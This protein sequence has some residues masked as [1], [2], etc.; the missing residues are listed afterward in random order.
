MYGNFVGTDVTGTSELGNHVGILVSSNLDANIGGASPGQGNLISGNR[1][2]GV[3]VSRF[4]FG[5]EVYGNRIGTD[6]TGTLPLGN[7]SD[8]VLIGGANNF[9]GGT[10]S[11]QGNIIAFNGGNGVNV[12]GSAGS[13]APSNRILSNSIF[14]NALLGIDLN[15]DGVTANDPGDIDANAANELINKPVV[16]TAFTNVTGVGV[17]ATLD[18]Q[19]S[20]SYTVQFFASPG[21][22]PSGEGEGKR[23]LGTVDV[24]TDGTGAVTFSAEFPVAIPAGQVV[25]ATA[26]NDDGTSEFSNAVP[27]TGNPPRVSIG[28]VTVT[29]GN[30]V[31]VAAMFTLSLSAAVNVPITVDY[32]TADGT[33]VAE[34]DYLSQAGKVTFNP[35]ETTRTVTVTVN[36]DSLVE[37]TETF[38]VNLSNAQIAGIADGQ[39]VGTI[40][41]GPTVPPPPP[42]PPPATSA[43]S[44]SDASVTEGNSG[45]KNITFTVALS[46]PASGPTSVQF[47]TLQGTAK[48][49][50]DYKGRTGTL[51]FATG[52]LSQ[53]VNIEVYGDTKVEPNEQFTLNLKLP[54]G[55]IL[56][57]ALGI[58]TIVNNDGATQPPPPPTPPSKPR[59]SVNDVSTTE[60]NSSGKDLT[61]TLKLDKSSSQTITVEVFTLQGTAKVTEDYRGKTGV[62]TFAPG[63]TT[64][65][66]SIHVLGDTKDESNEQFTFNLKNAVNATI[67]DAVGIGT[68]IDND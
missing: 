33:A 8:G 47:F 5:V 18:A 22:D 25:T 60:G 2:F 43:F 28:D 6:V 38:K 11:G 50:E 64:R 4:A 45:S 52:Q 44:V 40:L 9:V 13:T 48:V 66:V 49:G 35:G 24:I 12:R 59:I 26:T 17:N 51:N 16:N 53:L 63:Q 7:D 15:G 20:T 37:G 30:G 1:A 23:L 36:P 29:E 65:T 62:V 19:P 57:D 67:G 32:A 27:V 56:G 68:I 39:G 34:G 58:G 55:A 21:P 54:T 61:F 3:S 41:D 31:P 14:S 42:P 46:A 10:G